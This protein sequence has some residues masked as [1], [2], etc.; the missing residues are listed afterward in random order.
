MIVYLIFVPIEIVGL[1]SYLT[2]NVLWGTLGHSGVEPFPAKLSNWP[3]LKIT[4]TST[5]HAE[6]HEHPKYNF[7]FYT[8]IWDKLFGTIDPDYEKRFKQGG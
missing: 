1:I 5:F 8:L 6:H 3:L 2:L 7:G 4:G